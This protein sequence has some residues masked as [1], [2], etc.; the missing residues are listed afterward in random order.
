MKSTDKKRNKEKKKVGKNNKMKKKKLVIQMILYDNANM[1]AIYIDIYK[2]DVGYINETYMKQEW[3]YGMIGNCL[4]YDK[5][6]MK[7][8]LW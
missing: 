2:N 8:S 7:L 4:G 6:Y 1:K 3:V 5:H